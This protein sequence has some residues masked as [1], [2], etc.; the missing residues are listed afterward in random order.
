VKLF[1]D[2]AERQHILGFDDHR[3]MLIGIPLLAWVAYLL[4]KPAFPVEATKTWTGVLSCY[5][6]GLAHTVVYWF[7]MRAILI[8]LRRRL[9]RLEQTGR[10]IG[11][12]L[13]GGLV[14]VVTVELVTDNILD[15]LLRG[16]DFVPPPFWFSVAACM[17]LSVLVMAIY[18]SVYFFVRYRQS[19]IEQERLAKA[20]MQAQLT[21]LKQQ[22]N[23]HFLFNSLN[24]LVDLIPEDPRLATQFVQRLSA[25]Y[26]RILE[27]RHQELIDLGTELEALQDY[28]F[29]M[30][31]RFQGK[32][33]VELN[34]DPA[35]HRALVVPLSLQLLVEN[36]IKHNVVSTRQPLYISVT[37]NENR[38][39]VR[40]DY[41]PR[42]RVDESTGIGQ[43]NI[44]R[45]YELLGYSQVMMAVSGD[46]YTVRLPLIW[47]SAEA[48]A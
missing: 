14:G 47:E 25:V 7:L 19:L 43:Q 37:A 44:R 46:S 21:A 16:G 27:Y 22:T 15:R 31:V 10:R 13:L 8:V 48:Y 38:I 33:R 9:P 23:P 17:L 20:N 45:R 36:A 12:L 2:K 4:F 34:V 26:R 35:Y 5:T 42:D 29:L 18:E 1:L 28:V 39:E 6:M 30:Q 32:L 41:R 11:F 24:T 40:N 3:A